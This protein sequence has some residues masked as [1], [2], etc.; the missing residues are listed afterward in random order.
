VVGIICSAD[1]PARKTL[2]IA[3]FDPA[4]EE[5]VP[6]RPLLR[7]GTLASCLAYYG[8]LATFAQWLS[9]VAGP[10]E[11][12]A[13]GGSRRRP[14][15]Q[16]AC[17]IDRN[18][19]HRAGASVAASGCCSSMVWRRRTTAT[20]FAAYLPHHRLRWIAVVI[21]DRKRPYA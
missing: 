3:D 2:T 20:E 4:T 9:T 21:S 17:P 8:H 14:A 5:C 19:L 11:A 16:A 1:R 6:S 15:R 7:L 13:V 12:D 10:V 18:N